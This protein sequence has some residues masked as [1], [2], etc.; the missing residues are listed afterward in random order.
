MDAEVA[1]RPTTANCRIE[2]PADTVVAVALRRTIDDSE[3]AVGELAETISGV[4]LCHFSENR[5]EA[6]GERHIDKAAVPPD[7]LNDPHQVPGRA[8]RRLLKDH[9]D[10]RGN[11]LKG[12]ARDPVRRTHKDYQV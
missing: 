3:R 12:D 2:H 10:I 9:W 7:G 5:P 1:Q 6:V 4:K 11:D 8:G